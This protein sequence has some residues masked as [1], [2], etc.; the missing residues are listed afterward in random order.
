MLV[1]L[2]LDRRFQKMT[3]FSKFYSIVKIK[4]FV[5]LYLPRFAVVG[6]FGIPKYPRSFG[7]SE[8]VIRKINTN[9]DRFMVTLDNAIKANDFTWKKS[10]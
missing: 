5:L 8:N 10:V 2:N 1:K 3:L 9:D 4:T 6:Y 7:V